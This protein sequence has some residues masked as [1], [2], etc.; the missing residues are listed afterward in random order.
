M[1]IYERIYDI[2]IE[3]LQKEGKSF[4]YQK[5]TFLCDVKNHPQIIDISKYLTLTNPDFF[6]AVYVS[7]YRRLPDKKTSIAWEKY[8]D[9]PKQIFQKKV[10][11]SVEKSSVAAIN[12]VQFIYNPY[13]KQHRGILYRMMGL[14]Y[15]LT[16]KSYLREFGK[17]LPLPI[18]KIIRKVFI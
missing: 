7:V 15:G 3:N 6:Q 17:K 14:L 10:L 2:V 5:T 1:Q 13:F 8:F 16:D 12:H 9:L 11:K 4:E 18:Q